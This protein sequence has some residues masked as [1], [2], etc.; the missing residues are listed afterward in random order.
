M[1]TFCRAVSAFKAKLK[2][3]NQNQKPKEKTFFFFYEINFFSIFRLL[4]YTKIDINSLIYNII[5]NYIQSCLAL[6]ALLPSPLSFRHARSALVLRA[7]VA[8]IVSNV[9][10]LIALAAARVRSVRILGAMVVANVLS[11]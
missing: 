2:K 5:T 3:N 7:V 1:P 4:L 8:A 11:A 6:T 9:L 10:L